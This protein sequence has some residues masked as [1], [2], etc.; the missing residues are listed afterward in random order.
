ME[1]C[2]DPFVK[3]ELA[4]LILILQDCYDHL[5]IHQKDLRALDRT[6][7]SLVALHGNDLGSSQIEYLVTS[8]LACFNFVV[9][10]SKAEHIQDA[11]FSRDIK[12]DQGLWRGADHVDHC[13]FCFKVTSLGVSY[14]C[15]LHQYPIYNFPCLYD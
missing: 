7:F 8:I 9:F 11:V 3:L 10:S 14:I 12:V 15:P 6:Y 13:K 2:I 4:L 5:V 1:T